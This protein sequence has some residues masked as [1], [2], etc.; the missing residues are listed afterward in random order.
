MQNIWMDCDTGM[1]DLFALLVL[2]DD[3]EIDVVGV[4]TVVGNT[5]LDHATANTLAAVELAGLEVPVHRGAAKPLAQE[6]QTI[7]DLLG[8]GAMGTLGR[9]LAVATSEAAPENAVQALIGALEASQPGALTILGT[10]PLTNVAMALILRPDLADR[11][12]RLVMMGGSATSGNH[13]SAAEF[14]V[15]AD[16]EAL[17]TVLRAGLDVRVFGLNLTRQ[18]LVG[19]EHE[20]ELRDL[21]GDA[22]QTLADLLGAYLRMI[23]KTT[24]RAMPLHDP[25]AAAYLR[26]PELFTLQPAKVDVELNRGVGRGA[27]FCEFRLP[28]KGEP[29][30][31]VATEARGEEVMRRVMDAIR[32]AVGHGPLG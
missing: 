19:P 17:D 10:G 12:G 1:D 6:P 8:E 25:S 32:G 9:R 22:G 3:P 5:S 21:G 23:D 27:T 24:A 18:V 30:A 26:W 7:E 20:Q 4:S 11:V 2:A 16:P 31:L 13:T 28:R 14:N 29:N 15:Y